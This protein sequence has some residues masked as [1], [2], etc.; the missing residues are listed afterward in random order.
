MPGGEYEGVW[1]QLALVSSKQICC[2]LEEHYVGITFKWV[3]IFYIIHFMYIYFYPY[4]FS[5]ILCIICM[6]SILL[7]FIYFAGNIFNIYIALWFTLSDGRG[8][9]SCKNVV[10]FFRTFFSNFFFELFFRT[11]FSNFFSTDLQNFWTFFS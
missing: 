1:G 2:Q 5:K 10:T 4:I 11:F 9:G 6:C 8:K 7:S 3:S